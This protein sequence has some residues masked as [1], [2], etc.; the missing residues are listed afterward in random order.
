M[1]GDEINPQV[2]VYVSEN[3]SE[4]ASGERE[5]VRERRRERARARERQRGRARE[6]ERA[7]ELPF[8]PILLSREVSSRMQLGVPTCVRG[9]GLAR[10]RLG[11]SSRRV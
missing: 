5:R 4:R 2:C 6:R 8:V 7:R 10:R 11:C 3:E 1:Y 9:M